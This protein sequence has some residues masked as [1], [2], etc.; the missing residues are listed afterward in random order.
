MVTTRWLS[1]LLLASI[2]SS[3]HAEEDDLD[4]DELPNAVPSVMDRRWATS[5][6]YGPSTLVPRS[7]D[8]PV[9]VMFFGELSGRYRLVPTVELGL[10][11]GGVVNR[12][13]GYLAALGDVR[14]R[15]MAERPWNPFL[16]TSIGLARYAAS[17]P[18]RVIARAGIGIE[19]RF[20]N[21]AFSAEAQV[22]RIAGVAEENL[23]IVSVFEY[24]GAWG[25]SG[26]MSAIYY[27]GE[28]RRR[29]KPQVERERR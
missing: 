12:D 7:P 26:S 9:K 11:L 6:T 22:S 8:F 20:V 23:M 5:A 14:Y 18:S 21:W 25:A 16:L 19:R 13:D 2:A 28:G 24:F 4:P 10:S 17:Q 15:M 29:I 27:W 3:A 1:I